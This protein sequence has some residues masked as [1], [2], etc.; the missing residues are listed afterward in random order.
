M[1]KKRIIT[2]IALSLLTVGCSKNNLMCENGELVDG[3]CK[4]VEIVEEKDLPKTDAEEIMASIKAATQEKA[5]KGFELPPI[6]EKAPVSEPE[7]EFPKIE[8]PVFDN[9]QAQ[10]IPTK[11]ETTIQEEI[12]KV[13]IAEPSPTKFCDNCGIMLTEYTSICPSCGEP[14]D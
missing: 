14:I 13:L 2:L 3:V 12:Q 9:N 1:K 5:A 7:F 10:V 11:V 8:S 6:E 4:N